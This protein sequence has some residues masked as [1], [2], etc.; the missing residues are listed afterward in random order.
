MIDGVEDGFGELV[1]LK[2][3]AKIEQ[4]GSVRG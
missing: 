3:V 4:R 2:Q 1:M